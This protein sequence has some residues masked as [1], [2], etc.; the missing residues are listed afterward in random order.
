MRKVLGLTV[1]IAIFL[2]STPAFASL[3]TV[4]FDV[5]GGGWFQTFGPGSPFGLTSQPT[6]SGSVTI[7]DTVTSGAAFVGIDYTTGSRTW[8]LSDID[9]TT[10]F[11]DYNGDGSFQQFGIN[12][13]SSLDFLYSSNTVGVYDGT[14]GIACNFCFTVTSISGVPEMSTWALMLLGFAGL[15]WA[16]Y[17]RTHSKGTAAPFAL[18]DKGAEAA[19]EIFGCLRRERA[20]RYACR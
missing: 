9:Q 8:T 3:I 5:I 4:D 13:T 16:A 18:C 2:A 17:R 10:S 14:N 11:V 1:A 7:D 15:G 19:R 6:L 20:C 12:F